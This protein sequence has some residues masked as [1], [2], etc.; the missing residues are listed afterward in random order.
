MAI[1]MAKYTRVITDKAF[2]ISLLATL[3]LD[4][5]CI[6][7]II[8]ISVISFQSD[9]VIFFESYYLRVLGFTILQ[10]SLAAIFCVILSL[11]IVIPFRRT[12]TSWYG[13]IFNQI[14]SLPF[15]IPSIVGCLALVSVFGQNSVISYIFSCHYIVY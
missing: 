12:S 11:L 4:S 13:W 14:I 2:L 6:A 10:A 15:F 3:S 1:R 8:M 5:L 7:L 9:T